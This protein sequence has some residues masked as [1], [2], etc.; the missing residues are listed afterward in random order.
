[1]RIWLQSSAFLPTP[2]ASTGGLESVVANLAAGL[3]DRGHAVTLFGLQGSAVAGVEVVTVAP[4]RGG[5]RDT[6]T[7]IV[8]H[9]ERL[10]HPDVLF[11]HSLYQLAQARWPSLPAVTQ[12][13][14][15]AKIS[16]HA[17]NPVFCSRHHG[18]S[19]GIADPM[20]ALIN[21]DPAA[22]R[23][24]GPMAERGPPLFLGR[25]MPYKRVH[26]AADLC[27]TAGLVLDI[28]GPA[29]DPAY[30]DAEILP[31]MRA[32]QVVIRGEVGGADKA[33]LLARACC[34]MFTS[35]PEEP[36]G[37]VMLEAMAAGTPV[38]A[39]DHGAN[40]EYIVHGETGFLWADAGQF[41]NGLR[42]RRWLE[43]DPAACR[44]HVEAT[45]SPAKAGDR[46][47]ALLRQAAEG[48]RW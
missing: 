32:G 10:P 34:L 15:W 14:G 26:H 1:M 6:E 19:H 35:E 22:Y 7:A 23:L 47:E 46:I 11:D 37:T 40:P 29:H 4:M 2:P 24:G 30:F 17:R 42:G 36:S 18:Q 25:I 28:A 9:M 39:Y 43:I 20:V 16:A 5:A 21:V 31:R 41:L 27:G 33:A 44:R 3:R 12:S 48:E 8:D 38:F 13:H 45:F